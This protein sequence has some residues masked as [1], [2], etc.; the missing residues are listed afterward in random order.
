MELAYLGHATCL[1]S[2]GETTV[3]TD[4][5]LRSRLGPLRRHGPAPDLDG[6]DPDLVV[7]SHIH[8][9]HLDLPSLRRLDPATRV[10]APRGAAAV[11]SGAGLSRITEVSAGEEVPVNGLS[12]TVTQAVH[13]ERR[14][15]WGPTATPVGFVLE[16]SGER[17]Y[18]PGDTDVFGGM[19]ELGPLDLALMPVWGWGPNLG[20][21]HLDPA[22]SAHAL[23]LIRPRVAVPIHWGTLYPA[24]LGRVRPRPLTEPPLLFA[25]I[26]AQEAPQ[27]DVRVLQPGAHTEVET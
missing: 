27:V 4:P 5:F 16:R 12:I 19:A 21:G 1:V 23:T 10:V 26:A 6:L 8:R 14:D 15:P 3:L 20:P 11:L 13:D 2:L 17:A 22:A 18:F 9:D 7:I 24:G 25:R